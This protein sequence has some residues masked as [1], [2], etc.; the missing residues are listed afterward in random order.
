M[1]LSKHLQLK[2]LDEHNNICIAD[3]SLIII[4]NNVCT[5]C[6]ARYLAFPPN[7]N[8]IMPNNQQHNYC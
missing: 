3:N 4:R 6:S 8:D 1:V 2:Q 5:K 7:I